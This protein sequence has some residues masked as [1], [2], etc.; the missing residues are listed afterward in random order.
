MYLYIYIY[1]Y[2]IV[3]ESVYHSSPIPKPGHRCWFQET[4]R[5]DSVWMPFCWLEMCSIS[6][7][8]TGRINSLAAQSEKAQRRHRLISANKTWQ[9]TARNR[10]QRKKKNE[11]GPV[12]SNY[13]RKPVKAIVAL[14]QDTPRLRGKPVLCNAN[15]S[16]AAHWASEK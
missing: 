2:G 1:T 9:A 7:R 11:N 5:P 13:H 16:H 12:E 10:K 6:F 14:Y 4:A 15:F 3:Y 8:R